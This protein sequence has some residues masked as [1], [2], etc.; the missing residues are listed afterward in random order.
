MK[1]KYSLLWLGLTLAS[2]SPTVVAQPLTTLVNFQ[3]GN[4]ANPQ[5]GL[6]AGGGTLYGTTFSGGTSN[7]GTIFSLSPSGT[8]TTLY[9]FQGATYNVASNGYFPADGANPIGNLVLSTNTLY[10][11][12]AFG[13]ASDNGSIFSISTNGSNYAVIYSFVGGGNGADPEAGLALQGNVLYGT[14]YSGGS[15][16]NGI[17][18]RV[19]TSGT[20]FTNIWT[21]SGGAN[22]ANPQA[23]L[24]ISGNTLFGTTYNGGLGYGTIFEV[25]VDGTGFNV[26]HRFNGASDGAYP[27]AA[28]ILKGA[29]L[30]G[31]ASAGGDFGGMG[32]DGTVFAFNINTSAFQAFPLNFS[33]GSTPEGALLL[34]EGVLY[35]TTF[36]GGEP[37]Y[38]GIFS[39]STNGTG[40]T[41]LYAFNDAGD[42]ANPQAGLTLLGTQLYGTTEG[43]D[44]YGLGTVFAL[45]G[46]GVNPMLNIALAGGQLVLTWNNPA[47]SLYSAPGVTTSAG[48]TLV[49]GAT[50]PYTV[51]PTN[52]LGY[53]ILKA[54]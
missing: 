8:L 20:G 24:V 2:F 39:I 11:A 13:G 35:G 10:G 49:P 30:Y 26:L 16:G 6:V 53:F 43:D 40:L 1:T 34:S 31:T 47:F 23:A 38:G 17:V 33:V 54:N 14:T 45:S 25:N 29:T 15:S 32:G 52:T 44:S 28:M 36:N 7:A 41:N 4:G 48:F 37:G 50:S 27:A 46:S 3:G 51:P 22:G 12:T 21:F 18:F 42:G 19:N 5:S 9:N